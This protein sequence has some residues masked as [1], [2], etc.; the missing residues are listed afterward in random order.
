ML[1][2]VITHEHKIARQFRHA[3]HRQRRDLPAAAAQRLR[4]HPVLLEFSG[5]NRQVRVA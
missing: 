5:V 4:Q 3:V 2:E 1:Y